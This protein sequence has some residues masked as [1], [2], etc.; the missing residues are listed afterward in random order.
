VSI[1]FRRIVRIF[2][3]ISV[4]L[5]AGSLVRHNSMALA[6]EADTAAFSEF[7]GDICHASQSAADDSGADRTGAP[8]RHCPDCLNCAASAAI[9]PTIAVSFAASLPSL[10]DPAVAIEMPRVDRLA[11]WPPGRAPPF[12]A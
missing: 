10:N 6:A 12:S 4:L 5:H 9:L 2:A 8:E 1:L 3:I 11:L 7:F